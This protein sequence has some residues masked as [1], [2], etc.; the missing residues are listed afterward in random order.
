[1]TAGLDPGITVLADPLRLRQV[2]DNLMSNAIKYTTAG[3]AVRLGG[4]RDGDRVLLSIV[5]TGIGIPADEYPKL[6]TRFFRASTAIEGNVDGT[7]L[8]LAITKAIVERH[9]G[10]IDARPNDGGGTVFTVSLLAA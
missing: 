6:F 1:M 5:D 8:G 4:I 2:L 10:T 9:G 7:G 3:G